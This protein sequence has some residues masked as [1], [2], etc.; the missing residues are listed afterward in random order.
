MCRVG[1]HIA[2][3]AILSVL[4]VLI[5]PGLVGARGPL[6]RFRPCLMIAFRRAVRVH[7][8]IRM[9]LSGTGLDADE[10]RRFVRQDSFCQAARSKVYQNHVI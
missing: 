3:G 5:P 7:V 2:L 10:E 6:V 4:Q 1:D 9:I 8:D